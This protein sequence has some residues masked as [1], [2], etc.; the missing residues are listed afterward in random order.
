MTN[1]FDLSITNI[2]D[3][4]NLT[5]E[6]NVLEALDQKGIKIKTTCGGVGSCGDCKII[7]ENGD[8]NL[9]PMTLKE[10]QLLGNVFFLT[11]E[12]LACQC[13]A[14]HDVTFEIVNR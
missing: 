11:K 9:S 6:T 2:S 12:R 8:K 10:K 13:I 7:I 4:I 14:S 3:K 5:I 1:S